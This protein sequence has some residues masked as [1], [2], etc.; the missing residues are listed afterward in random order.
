MISGFLSTLLAGLI[1]FLN[2]NLKILTSSKYES[3]LVCVSE[4]TKYYAFGFANQ[5]VD[6]F[7]IRFLQELDAYNQLTIADPHLCPDKISSWHFHIV[8]VA[9]DLDRNFLELYLHA[10]LLVAVTIGDTQGASI[11]FDKSVIAFPNDW[12]ILYRA[13]YQAMIEE[14]NKPKAADLLYRAGKNGAP[15]WVMSLAGGLFNESGD[16]QMAE[17]IYEE[18]LA[19]SKD[20]D[21]AIRLKQKLDKKLKNFFIQ[22]NVPE[23]K[24]RK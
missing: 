20:E 5:M 8:N 15:S 23:V 14:K 9:F 16:R 3:A 13:A 24:V 2:I 10:P 1:L 12:R 22:P 11:L 6:S 4:Y 18:L 19:D 21:A 17:R 7:W